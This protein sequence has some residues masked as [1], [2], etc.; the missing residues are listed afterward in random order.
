MI[1]MNLKRN[2]HCSTILNLEVHVITWETLGIPFRGEVE[3]D[4]FCTRHTCIMLS[5]SMLLLLSLLFRIL[6]VEKDCVDIRH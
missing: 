4:L 3:C 2:E 6:S 1:V 5:G